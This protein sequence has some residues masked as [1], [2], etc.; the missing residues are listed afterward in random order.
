MS[1]LFA[2]A[3][4]VLTVAPAP[5]TAGIVDYPPAYFAAAHPTTARD[6]LDRIPGFTFDGGESVRGYEGAAG[7]VLVDGQRPAAK[8]DSLDAILRRIPTSSVAHIEIIRGGASGI[9]MQG[10]SV[11]ANVV[12]KKDASRK[13]QVSTVATY[14]PAKGRLT[15][16]VRVVGSGGSNDRKWEFSLLGLSYID[17]SY[18]DG[19]TV[20]TNSQA[21]VIQTGRSQSHAGGQIF[22]VTGAYE[23]PLAGGRLRLNGLILRSPYDDDISNRTLT[24]TSSVEREH[25]TNDTDSSEFGLR[26]SRNLGGRT[27]I[28]LV[29]LR[30]A[31]DIE[32]GDV[33]KSPSIAVDFS[34]N[35]QTEEKILRGVLRQKQS[36]TFSW[37]LGA[38]GAWNTLHNRLAY[39]EGG[40]KISLPSANVTVTENRYEAIAKA[41]W[42]PNA[43]WT[44]ET[45]LRQELSEIASE[46]D[47]VL[48]KSLSYTKPR[49]AIKWT[50]AEGDQIRFRLER[51]VGQL[52]FTDFT[53]TSALKNGLVTAGNPDLAP[54]EGWAAE[55]TSEHKVLE[56]G[57]VLLTGRHVELTNVIDRAPIFTKSG[58]IDSPANIGSGVKDELALNATLPLDKLGA[59]GFQLQSNVT[60]RKSQVTDPTT[61]RKRS[62]SNLPDK[63]WDV[64]LTWDIP[65]RN[66]NL[67]LSLAEEMQSANYRFNQIETLKVGSY[68][69]IAAV[70]TPD[71]RTVVRLEAYNLTR[72]HISYTND[73][74]VSARSSSGLAF[75]DGRVETLGK[76]ISVGFRRSF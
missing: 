29:A 72:Q 53:A 1:L 62:I 4:A 24:P 41:S 63:T 54:E 50:Y 33:V 18:G 71:P 40:Q 46:G 47:T 61:G 6:M 49:L 20:R 59:T 15:P 19:P 30:Q 28:E 74:F 48:S 51:E 42:S 38:E 5:T 66:L 75:R 26:Y 9:D 37:E 14:Q 68:L 31:K 55:L 27:S 10:R 13:I 8:T 45:D 65:R 36:P 60:W 56:R 76:L 22:Q 64:L 35:S 3:Q 12:L 21:S 69:K 7:N 70:W 58:A 39:S 44:V 73:T 34:Q 52:K 11:L 43:S 32:F 67:A 2:V 17:G 23:V 16:Q 25:V 57:A